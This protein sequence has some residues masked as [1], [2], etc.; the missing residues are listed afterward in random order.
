MRIETEKIQSILLTFY[1]LQWNFSFEN[2]TEAVFLNY[3]HVKLITTNV[4][5]LY[6]RV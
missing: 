2:Q 5:Q 4:Q 1:F 6:H 3:L